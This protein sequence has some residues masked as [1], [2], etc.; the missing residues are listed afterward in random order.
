MLT[1]SPPGT[2]KEPQ[3]KQSGSLTRQNEIL[4]SLVKRHI[5]SAAELLPLLAEITESLA[6]AL[7]VERT[8]VWILNEDRSILR[9]VDLFEQSRRRHS[10]GLEL[11]VADYPKYFE[12]LESARAIDASQTFFDPRTS[13]FAEAYLSPFSITS[14]LDVAVWVD[15]ALV[16]VVC[17]EHLGQARRWLDSERAFVS[18]IADIVAL[19]LEATDRR[20]AEEELEH[21][22]K[23]THLIA[24]LSA[25]LIGLPQVRL[26]E[27]ISAALAS[28]AKFMNA[29]QAYIAELSQDGEPNLSHTWTARD[30]M[31]H[32]S[33]TCLR[34]EDSV[35]QLRSGILRTEGRTGDRDGEP[36][37]IIC[38]PLVSAQQPVGCLGLERFNEDFASSD[39][40]LSLL[41]IAADIFV[42]AMERRRV[43][44]QLHVM[45]FAVEKAADPVLW[46]G[47]DGRI[48]YANDAACQHLG[49][50]RDEILAL[51][52]FDIA[53]EIARH[54]WPYRWS[55]LRDRQSLTYETF[56]R[57]KSGEAIPV[58]ITVNYFSFG[59][60]EYHCVSVRNIAERKRAEAERA[61]ERAFFR[62]VIDLNPNLIFA[63]DREGRFTLVNQAV[64]DVYGTTVEEIV[65]KTDADFDENADEVEH[66]RREDEQ[67]L[68]SGSPRFIPEERITDASG[69]LRWLQTVKIPF[70]ADGG[71]T[72]NLVLGVATDITARKEAEEEQRQLIAQIER[73]QKWE[74]LGVLAG[75]VAHDFNNLLMGILGNASLAAAELPQGSNVQIRI[76]RIVTAGKRA[77]E[78]TN[79]LLAYAGRGQ[80]VIGPININS[81]VTEMTALLETIISKKAELV[82]RLGDS[83]PMIQGDATQLRQVVMNLITNASDALEG[84]SGTITLATG[85]VW[86]TREFLSRCYS[87]DNLHE[88]EYAFIQ[89]ADDGAGIEREMLPRIFDPFFTTKFTGRGLGL[90]AVLGIVRSHKGALHVASKQGRGTRFTVYIPR[91]ENET[92]GGIERVAQLPKAGRGEAGL[93]LVVDDDDS[94]REVVCDLFQHFGYEVITAENGLV[95][96]EKFRAHADELVG[97]FLDMTMPVLDG[98]ETWRRI[99]EIRDDVP[100]ILTS[101]YSEQE[102]VARFTG[103]T[104]AA[105]IQKPYDPETLRDRLSTVFGM[106][107]SSVTGFG[108]DS[109]S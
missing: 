101:G 24:T 90:A 95:A 27:G 32:V 86:A 73:A 48:N 15:G 53:P 7:E 35:Q 97:V 12:A 57:T 28:I 69:R 103:T 98:E 93:I 52:V 60:R 16:G 23:L 37:G 71:A 85:T 88:G 8:S 109:D 4:V 72:P 96:V 54:E 50:S 70:A 43:E 14:M 18:S 107:G 92:A 89:V 99:C 61:R 41:T 84:R 13:E 42:N 22:L 68:T 75:G 11:R 91:R 21:R 34:H 74:S 39:E 6:S 76:D 62:K 58:E 1:S 83:P 26:S 108:G 10:T 105:F 46:I 30:E 31:L 40:T 79:Q 51:E 102:T 20:R 5:R 65:G 38:V 55:S 64:A 33:S 80:Y 59:D 78:L 19:A 66:F 17:C 44:E 45:R 2:D 106:T 36:A 77:A 81:L 29:D 67:V 56:H 82:L 100:L 104:V 25:G 87:D 63:K 94:V 9:C 3:P 47:V 49:Y